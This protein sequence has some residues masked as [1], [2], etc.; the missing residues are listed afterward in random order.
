[1]FSLKLE[2]RLT[3]AH[4]RSISALKFSPNGLFLASSSISLIFLISQSVFSFSFFCSF[5]FSCSALGADCTVK[6]FKFD[7]ED[8]APVLVFS[9]GHEKGISDISWSPDGKYIASASDDTTISIWSLES[10]PV[11]PCRS[12][13][14][15]SSYVYCV[16]FSPTGTILASGGFDDSLRL[17]NVQQGRIFKEIPAHGDPITSVD[18]SSDGTALLTG[19]FD[20]LMRLWDV[21][22]GRCLKTIVDNDNPPVSSAT[23]TPNSKYILT[24]TLDNHIRLWSPSTAKCVRTFTAEGYTTQ[25]YSCPAWILTHPVSQSVLLLAASEDGAIYIWNLATKEF[26]GRHQVLED[27]SPLLSLA[28]SP[29]QKF[30]VCA[31]LEPNNDILVFSLH[32][33]K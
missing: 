20:G 28:I 23:F 17:W 4:F 9:G 22:S 24:T 33:E 32:E 15:H 29:D 11:E 31:G 18:F 8:S 12:L 21:E 30:I 27:K 1:M 2:R 19:S 13:R 25:K 3:S 14:G 16:A 6:V 26:L 10:D 5:S 7:S